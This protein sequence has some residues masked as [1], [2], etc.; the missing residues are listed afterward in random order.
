MSRTNGGLLGVGGLEVLER[1]VAPMINPDEDTS[2]LK[3]RTIKKKGAV[4]ERK[5]RRN[6]NRDVVI[7]GPVNDVAFNKRDYNSLMVKGGS[8]GKQRLV[9]FPKTKEWNHFPNT[10][11][12]TTYCK[13][14]PV[15]ERIKSNENAFTSVLE[16]SCEENIVSS[17]EI[18]TK[19]RGTHRICNLSKLETSLNDK[20]N[21]KCHVNDVIE[22]FIKHCCIVDKNK[23]AKL[24][25]L[26]S[27]YKHKERKGTIKIK[28]TCLGVATSVEI[29]CSSCLAKAVAVASPSRFKTTNLSGKL[30]DHRRSNSYSSNL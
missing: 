23:Y 12:K 11:Y 27:N 15:Q 7:P 5:S 8:G 22:D 4:S 25:G 26:Y 13:L 30:N 16:D 18:R 1:E 10:K 21:C 24:A 2:G 3:R 14:L 9:E 29:L 6:C 19:E 20:L 17:K 28:D